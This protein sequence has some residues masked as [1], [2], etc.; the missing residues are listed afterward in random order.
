MGTIC[1]PYAVNSLEASGAIFY[2]TA[3]RI[4]NSRIYFNQVDHLEAGKAYIFEPTSSK[5]ALAQSGEAVA[6]PIAENGLVGTFGGINTDGQ[7]PTA[8]KDMYI[9]TNNEVRICG[10]GCYL[11]A[12]RAYIN[13]NSVTE[14]QSSPAPNR[15]QIALSTSGSNTPTELVGMQNAQC[16]MQ[17]GKFILNGQFVILR[18]GKMFNAQGAQL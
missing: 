3:Y 15:R 16:T 14:K 4:G 18:D 12:N 13:L 9:L 11:V 1:L 8:L 17:N 10:E 2:K 7:S 6:N 5:I